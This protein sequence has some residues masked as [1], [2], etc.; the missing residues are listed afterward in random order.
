MLT[1]QKWLTTQLAGALPSTLAHVGCLPRCHHPLY[2]G[3]Q[4]APLPLSPF[5][6][7]DRDRMLLGSA[8]QAAAGSDPASVRGAAL[9]GPAGLLQSTIMVPP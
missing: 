8:L 9:C 2:I 7:P 1:T 4:P 5:S 3:Q 6:P